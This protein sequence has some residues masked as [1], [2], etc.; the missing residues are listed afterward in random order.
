MVTIGKPY[1]IGATQ[2]YTEMSGMH[3]G[4]IVLLAGEH[5]LEWLHLLDELVTWFKAQGCTRIDGV[6]RRG[7]AKRL[8]DWTLTHVVLE[9]DV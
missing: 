3:I 6:M 1:A 5:S 2:I 9:R 8:S 4:N 7:W